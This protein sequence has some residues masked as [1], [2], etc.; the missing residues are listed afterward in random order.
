MK[1]LSIA[2]KL[3]SLGPIYPLPQVGFGAVTTVIRVQYMLKELRS[4][5]KLLLNAISLK[6]L[7]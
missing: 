1:F 6:P 2:G 3:F 7:G 5:S 4:H